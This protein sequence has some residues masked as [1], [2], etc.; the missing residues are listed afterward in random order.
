LFTPRNPS[1]W[2]IISHG[3]EE[4]RRRKHIA[5]K[6]L[7][8]LYHFKWNLDMSHLAAI[9]NLPAPCTTQKKLPCNT[10]VP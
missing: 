1:S 9:E 6:W 10:S 2:K 8:F 7:S 4:E 5:P 3:D